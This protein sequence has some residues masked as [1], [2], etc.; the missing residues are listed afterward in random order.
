MSLRC[1]IF[2]LVLLGPVI[3][4]A[5]A[6]PPRNVLDTLRTGHPRLLVLD[7]ELSRIRQ[8][9]R[10]QPLAERWLARLQDKAEAML[11][12]PPVEHVFATVRPRLLDKSRL[13][14]KRIST[15]AGLYRLSGD[16]RFAERARKEMLAVCAFED[17]G[18]RYFLDIAEMTT[19]VAIGYDWLFDELS[20]DDRAVIRTAIIEKGLKQ[21][22]PL[23]DRQKGWPMV[24]HNWNQVCNGG[25]TIGALAIADE[26][27]ALAAKIITAG[28]DSI[29]R[30]MRTFA[31]DGGWPEGPGYWNYA[32]RYN[33][34]Y[35]AAIESALGTDFDLKKMPGFA[36][37]GLFRI[38]NT[39]PTGRQ[40]NYA[41]GHDYTSPA[42]QMFWFA[43]TFNQPIC[44]GY[45]RDLAE[46]RPS[47]FHLLWFDE[48]GRS[49]RDDDLPLSAV[50]HNIDVA[51]LRSAWNDPDAVFIGFKGGDNAANH[52]HLDL[53]TF[54]L[55]ALGHRWALDLGPDDYG[56]PGYFGKQRY[57]YYRTS[58]RS[59]NTLTLDGANQNRRAAAPLIAFETSPQQSFAIADL[60]EA[61]APNV[62]SARRGIALLDRKQVLV[63]DELNIKSPAALRW[64]FMTE[65]GIELD[66]AAA[67]L[68]HGDVKLTARI[69]SPADARFEVLPAAA[70]AQERQQ[71]QVRNLSISLPATAGKVRIA[72]VLTPGGDG[73]DPPAIQPL[74]KWSKQ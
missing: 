18:P 60:T 53:G 41:D 42:A 14:L 52:S 47:I 29:V 20:D 56:L 36:Q 73:S 64:N 38:Y 7:D 21:S 11:D 35:L 69:L 48:R 25:M 9:I 34:F 51:F 31:P 17:W 8:T 67:T 26:E 70:P 65:A 3:H 46:R 15:L 59:H 1:A 49:P 19:A 28:R 44:A 58:T 4:H 71:P 57:S 74:D 50:Y 32:T 43:R 63:Q 13:A 16:K 30:A 61:Y 40:F 66:G 33:V 39:T 37:T 45:E 62:T 24:S 22:L 6:E 54:V 5:V 55:D 12:E 68:T 10:D 72:V 2:M 23:Y 27:P